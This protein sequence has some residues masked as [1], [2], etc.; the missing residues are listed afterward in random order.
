M[1]SVPNSDILEKWLYSVRRTDQ[2]ERYAAAQA[3]TGYKAEGYS[4]DEALDL[5]TADSFDTE[6]SKEVLS[7]VFGE[8]NTGATSAPV[9]KT[10]MVVPTSYRD[11]A[12][13][14]EE[15]LRAN[16]PSQFIGLLMDGEMPLVRASNRN[17]DSWKRLAHQAMT[18]PVAMKIL[19]TDLRP[20]LEDAMLNSVL[21]AENQQARVNAKGEKK[22]A[23]ASKES[24]A[25]VCLETGTCDCDRF[26]KS[27]FADF[28]IACEHLVHAK[29]TL[30][31]FERL[32]R[33]LR[34]K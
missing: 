29:H 20:W 16:S 2:G 10:A 27:N 12:P 18:D 34:S 30:H 1:S 26:V 31:P 21:I 3:A 13:V 8:A 4:A 25:N 33:A 6:L 14:V 9:E 19:H 11:I 17:R 5:M 23:V 15:T 22:Y 7:Q 32:T 24:R 28:G